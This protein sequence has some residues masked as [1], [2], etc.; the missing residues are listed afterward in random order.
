M[1]EA[2]FK[3]RYPNGDYAATLQNIQ[4]LRDRANNDLARANAEMAQLLLVATE[5]R[6]LDSAG[7]AQLH[8]LL[9]I[10]S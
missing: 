1:T 7:Q 3:T 5:G 6:P 4:N 8:R 9:G 2:E 10:G